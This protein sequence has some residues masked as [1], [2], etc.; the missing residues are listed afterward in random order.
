[1]QA[2]GLAAWNGPFGPY[3]PGTFPLVLPDP[4]GK[5]LEIE[6][7]LG[8]DDAS[9]IPTLKKINVVASYK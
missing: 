9:V 8:T 5:Y 4:V 2:L 7:T 1:M 3:P 6:V